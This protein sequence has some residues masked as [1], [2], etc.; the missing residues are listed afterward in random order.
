MYKLLAVPTLFNSFYVFIEPAQPYLLINTQF[1]HYALLTES[2]IQNCKI[3]QEQLYSCW[4]NRPFQTSGYESV[5]EVNILAH[6]NDL[7]QCNIRR[8]PPKPTYIPLKTP[9]VW[10]YSVARIHK[11]NLICG[12]YNEIIPLENTGILQ[13]RPP[14]ILK[15]SN[16]L[17]RSF[18]TNH[19]EIYTPI[20]S[21][22][23]LTRYVNNITHITDVQNFSFSFT[24]NIT[25][26]QNNINQQQADEA[27][28]N[29]TVHDIHHY[30]VGYTS[31]SLWLLLGVIAITWY[32]C[33]RGRHLITT[34]V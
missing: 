25:A 33:C 24:E 21:A 26:I 7:S 6:R 16:T 12:S 10:I 34:A 17:I 3:N 28:T 2:D 5:C 1:D 22:I 11:V 30:V 20:T 14:C 9:N 29:L 32:C 8:A 23:N 19:T 18:I 15:D 4:F 31:M 13:L 27:T